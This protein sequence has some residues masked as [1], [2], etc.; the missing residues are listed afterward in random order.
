MKKPNS[1]EKLYRQKP[2]EVWDTINSILNPPPKP[3]S[4]KPDTMNNY[5]VNIAKQTV[6]KDPVSSEDIEKL[7][8]QMS[9]NSDG[10]KM[11]KVQYSDVVKELTSFRNN[12][13]T[14]SDEIPTKFIKPI[15]YVIASSFTDIINTVIETS[16]FPH[17]W[18]NARVVPIPKVNYPSDTTDY[19][20]I[21]ILLVLS[22]IA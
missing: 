3:I 5:F 13:S 12:T 15:S 9:S 4:I 2:K 10:F 18:K 16:M 1:I 19:R 11:Q 7:I 8:T 20:P 14:E 17:Q 6:K 21:S 22:K